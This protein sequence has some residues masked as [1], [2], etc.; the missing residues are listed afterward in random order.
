MDTHRPTRRCAPTESVG[1]R[2]AEPLT[3]LAQSV[4]SLR[5]D[6]APPAWAEI[7]GTEAS[8]ERVRWHDGLDTL[9]GFVAP[10]DC[11]AVAAVGNGWARH[12]DN[13]TPGP[14]PIVAPGERRRCRVVF[15]LTRSG[16]AAGYLRAGPETLIH[17]PATQGRIPDLIRRCLG[18]PTP[19]PEETTAGFLARLWLN[20]IVGAGEQTATTGPLTWDSAAQ[21]HPALQVAAEAGLTLKPDQVLPALRVAADAWTWSHLARQAAQPG[22]L[23]DLLP[24]GAGAWM[25]EGILSRSLLGIVPPLESLLEGD[26]PFITGSTAMRLRV[27]LGELGVTANP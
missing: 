2:A 24:D 1:Q 4:E 26:K 19:P 23:R 20:N 11:F 5:P 9:T 17:E 18:L 27:V 7:Y 12:L 6:G 3:V 10:P 8:P 14:D 13:P 25:D 15:L 16:H 22:W 21:L